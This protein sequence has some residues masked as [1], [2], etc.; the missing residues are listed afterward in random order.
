MDKRTRRM[1]GQMISAGFPSPFVDEQARRITEEFEVGNYYIF[2]RNVVNT[3]QLC[4]LTKDLSELAF[5]K[6]GVSPF[7][8]LDQE[9]GAVSRIAVGASLFPGAMALA[10]S[11]SGQAHEVGKNSGEILRAL[12]L[13]STAAPVLD[14]N[15]E[16]LNPIIGARAFS[17]DTETVAEYG[18]KMMLG[19]KEGGLISTV[20]HYPGHGNV[21]SD[22]HLTLP[23]ND[24][25]RKTLEEKEWYP[26]QK[27]FDEGAEAIMSAHVVYPSV[28]PEWP[29][30]LSKVFMTDILRNQQH[31]TGIVET[32]CMEMD[33]VR[34]TY[35]IGPASVRAIEA[36]CDLLTF[37][38][39]YE[40]VK[41]GVTAIYEA[42]ESGRIPIKR[43]EESYMR[44]MALKEKYGLLQPRGIDNRKADE[45]IWNK[46]KNELHT[47]LSRN[48]ITLL[49]DNGGLNAFQNSKKPLFVAPPSLALNGAEDPKV[50]PL[51]FSETFAQKLGGT[52]IVIPLN[53]MNDAI[54]SKIENADF[55]AAVIGLYNARFRP[56]Q[57]KTLEILKNSGKPVICVLLGAPYDVSDIKDVSAV[58][59]AY[60]YTVL[61]VN[62]LIHALTHGEF[63]GKSPV[64]L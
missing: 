29:A 34:K 32:D 54:K 20:K 9:G 36:G 16:P 47:L 45:L 61:S 7:I 30:T 8:C 51:C 10:A 58:I 18:T 3:E 46:E 12:G 53:E 43:I 50:N 25:D 21:K 57:M 28:D 5:Q 64:K 4:A 27:A 22:S 17:D 24:T 39:T 15:V 49:S 62:S 48:S 6:N 33:A 2:G 23:F 11:G 35:G 41:E 56:G 55:D 1:I 42:V 31:F 14:V 44:I 19:L 38:H 26:F 13:T 52:S 59:A 40:A 60:E 37:S 63:P